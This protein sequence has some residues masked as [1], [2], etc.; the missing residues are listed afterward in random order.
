MNHSKRFWAEVIQFVPHAKK[1]QLELR[2]K[3]FN[4]LKL[5]GLKEA[6]NFATIRVVNY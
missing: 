4:E 2:K 5:E 6:Q 3:P 1:L